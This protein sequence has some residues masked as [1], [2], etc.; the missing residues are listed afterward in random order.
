LKKR[1]QG[2]FP[3]GCLRVSLNTLLILASFQG[4][5]EGNRQNML[6]PVVG[7]QPLVSPAIVWE[8]GLRNLFHVLDFG[9]RGPLVPVEHDH[10]NAAEGAL[11]HPTHIIGIIPLGE[12]F[13]L[14]KLAIW[15]NHDCICAVLSNTC[16]CVVARPFRR[17]SEGEA[18]WSPVARQVQ[19]ASSAT[20]PRND[21]WASRS[22][23]RAKDY[24]LQPTALSHSNIG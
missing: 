22:F 21:A 24:V 20:L 5:D 1:V 4:M 2:H 14:A 19:I 8:M 11:G 12:A 10:R 6:M 17:K 18:I 3:A 13:P 15:I 23:Y 7:Y 16:I 9:Y